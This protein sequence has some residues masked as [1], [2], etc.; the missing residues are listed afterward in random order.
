MRTGTPGFRPSRLRLAREA[1]GLTQ[2]ALAELVGRSSQSVSRWENDDHEQSPE[3]DALQAL[4]A[5][6]NVPV[7]GLLG[8]EPHQSPHPF[9]FR[10]MSAATKTLRSRM[11]A[12]MLWQQEVSGVLQ[13]HLDFPAVNVPQLGVTSHRQLSDQRIEE[14]AGELRALWGVGSGPIGDLLLVLENAGIIV[15]VVAAATDKLDGLSNWNSKDNR[16]YILL[17][18]DIPVTVRQRLDAAH[19]LGHLVLHRHVKMTELN[20]PADF[21]EIERQAFL[22]ASAFLMPAETFSSEVWSPS[23]ASFLSLKERWRVSVGAMVMR[24]RTLDLISP[25][26]ASRLWKHISAKGWRKGEPLDDKLPLER[27]RV[28]SRGV[29]MLVEDGGFAKADVI[30][31]MRLRERD[32]EELCGLQKGYLSSTSNVVGLVAMKPE[33]RRT[34]DVPSTVVPFRRR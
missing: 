3:P 33:A 32:I 34:H 22:F 16:P 25:E 19:E 8:M 26:Y 5:A 13:D 6:L 2:V 11:S 12:K 21:K 30:E 18:A 4:A 24:A 10:S 28:L 31:L 7:S 20:S 29:T 14:A 23:L 17:A 15:S 9:F 1:R 27:P